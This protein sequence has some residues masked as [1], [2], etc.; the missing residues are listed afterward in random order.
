MGITSNINGNTLTINI[1]GNFDFSAHKDFR[2]AMESIGETSVTD[3]V[4]N[5][6]AT[7]YVDSSALG[8][9]LMLKDR[10][11]DRKE[12]IVISSA[13]QKLRRF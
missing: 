12:C 7:D 6:G 1:A 11:G 8:M 9:L 5:M 13:K 4:V 10:M 2:A 3:A